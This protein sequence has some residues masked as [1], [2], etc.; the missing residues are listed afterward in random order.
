[1]AMPAVKCVIHEFCG[2]IK[3]L[4]KVADNEDFIE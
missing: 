1:M 2:V 3:T 4:K